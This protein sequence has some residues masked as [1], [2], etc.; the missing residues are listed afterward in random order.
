MNNR[1]AIPTD[2]L[3]R[4]ISAGMNLEYYA[5][6]VTPISLAVMIKATD[7]TT[8]DFLMEQFFWLCSQHF[9]WLRVIVNKNNIIQFLIYI[10]HKIFP[11]YPRRMW[12]L[13]S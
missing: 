7:K 5:K 10:G 9:Y 6:A 1:V 12:N 3:L 8:I 11:N 2:L 13:I 4:S